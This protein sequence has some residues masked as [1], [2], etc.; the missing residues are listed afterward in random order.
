M[1]G[2]T[3]GNTRDRSEKLLRDFIRTIKLVRVQLL[4]ISGRKVM[5]LSPGPNDVSRLAPGVYFIRPAAGQDTPGIQRV[6]IT[7]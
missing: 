7:R 4:G 5:D 3:T 2:N 6:V 1:T